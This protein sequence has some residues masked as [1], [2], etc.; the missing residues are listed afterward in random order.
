MPLVTGHIVFGLNNLHGPPLPCYLHEIWHVAI[1]PNRWMSTG[2]WH[3]YQMANREMLAQQECQSICKTF[4]WHLQTQVKMT[5]LLTNKYCCMASPY[6]TTDDNEQIAMNHVFLVFHVYLLLILKR[7]ARHSAK[8]QSS[9]WQESA[10]SSRR[11]ISRLT[12]SQPEVSSLRLIFLF[13]PIF[14]N[15]VNRKNLVNRNPGKLS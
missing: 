3:T 14:E 5:S 8:A 15:L 1:H 9:G 12:I 7:D 6:V 13:F 10:A 11:P 4:S 2:C